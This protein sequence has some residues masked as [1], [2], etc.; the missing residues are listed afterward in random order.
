MCY[1]D[2]ARPPTPPGPL[3]DAH[4]R[5]LELTAAD[6]NRFAATLALPASGNAT[7][8][9]LILPDIR[10]LHDFYKS[11][12]QRFAETGIAAIAMDYFGRTAGI[13]SRAEGFDF[14]PHV[15]QLTFPGLRADA[16]ASIAALNAATGLTRATTIGFCI[17][18]TI[19]FLAGTTELPLAGV[20]GFYAGVKRDISGGGLMIDRAPESRYPAL[21]LFG[22][23]DAGIPPEKVAEL[24]AA[25]DASGVAHEIVT[26]PGAPHS[27]F[28]R[29]SADFV[30]ASDD[31]WR[32]VLAFARS[33]AHT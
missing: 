6:G 26:Y 7:A 1:D 17:G 29:R 12:A 16:R 15:E 2:T 13:S 20:I 18:G 5:E 11:L 8:Q 3:G 14:W 33:N 25:L 27:F 30:E 32:R 9:M 22:G 21:G 4:V 10:G 19:S 24:D 28:D 23:D 31:A